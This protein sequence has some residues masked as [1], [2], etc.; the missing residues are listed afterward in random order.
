MIARLLE[1][2]PRGGFSLIE[3]M[4]ALAI[5]L[6]VVAALYNLFTGQVKAFLYQDIQ[7]EMHQNAR[8]AM[9]IVTRSARM[10]GA[11]TAGTTTGLFG[12]GGDANDPLPAIVSY[13]GTGPNGSDAVT[14]VS[15]DPSMV[16]NTWD[17][18]PPACTTTTL[19]FSP[20]ALDNSKKLAQLSS[21]ELLLCVDYASMSGFRS[22]LWQLTS[23]ASASTGQVQVASNSGLADYD[24]VCETDENLP[25]IMRCSRADIVTFYID[26]DDSDGMGAGSAEHPVLMMDMDL[27]APSANDVP[28]VDNVEDFQVRYCLDDDDPTTLESCDSSSSSWVDSITA[29]QVDNVYMVR[30]SLVVRSSREDPRRLHVGQR[31]ALEDNG[32]SSTTDNYFRQAVSTEV[33]VR[34]MRIQ[35][36]L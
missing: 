8:L 19:Q 16:M 12:A 25:L 26:A 23:D 22:W 30:I 24:A 17:D 3:L 6:F 33:T 2:R 1:R 13:N 4:F 31:P 29:D 21:G 10:A 11:G 28:L 32:A 7:A 27:D 36:K 34:N 14:F 9:D 15:M 20:S 18:A 35:A 5:G